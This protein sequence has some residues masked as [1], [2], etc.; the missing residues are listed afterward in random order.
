MSVAFNNIPGNLLTPFFFAEI[1]SGGSPFEQNPRLL[2]VGQKLSG[3][4]A[5]AA[6]PIGPIQSAQ[7]ADA[8]FGVGSMLS[9]MWRAAR[10]AAPFQPIWALPL[11]DPSGA[12]AVGSLTVTT[13]PGV[14]GEGLI[15]VLGRRISFQV[16]SADA[17]TVVATAIV[18]AIN[19]LGLPVTAAIDGTTA[20]KVNITAKHIGALGNAQELALVTDEA[21][22]MIAANNTIVAFTGGSGTPALATPLANCGDDEFDFIAAPYAD[23]SSLNAVR[24]FLNDQSGRWSPTKQL[25][26]HYYTAFFGNLSACVSLGN[27]RNDQHVSIMASQRSPSPEW[28]WAASLA[29]VAVAHLG[30]APELSRPLQTLT[31]PGIVPPRDRSLWWAIPD[32]Q[33]LYTDGMAAY[34]VTVDGQVAID[35]V[36]TTYQVTATGVADATF[37]DAETMAQLTFFIRYLRVAVSNRHGRQ[38]L[39][40][41]NPFNLAEIATPRSIRNTIVHAYNDLIA[42]GVAENGPLFAQFVV[43]ERDPNNA[44]RVNAFVPVDLVNQLR[45]IAVN[46]TAFL[47][48]QTPDGEAA[49]A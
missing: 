27:G 4:S 31:L 41:D 12:A 45:I 49:I 17:N 48:F 26:G 37:R 6:T 24:D 11:A 42:L 46:A 8:L 16:N 40:D 29:G 35:R 36:V 28:E 14:T 19:A 13:A 43:V 39:A 1:N 7:E 15:N 25:Y 22:V 38:A 5:V 30:D 33:A 20:Y 2:L 9:F 44:T 34:K 10:L 3:G 23:T 21:N 47:Q 32:R 18:A